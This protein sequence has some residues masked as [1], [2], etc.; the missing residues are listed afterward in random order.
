MSCNT[1]QSMSVVLPH[2]VSPT[3]DVSL[4]A[5]IEKIN[6]GWEQSINDVRNQ[7]ERV[8]GLKANKVREVAWIVDQC[9]MRT[10]GS[11]LPKNFGHHLWMVPREGER[12]SGDGHASRFLGPKRGTDG[13][14]EREKGREG[15]RAIPLRVKPTEAR[16]E[17]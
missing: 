14:R 15:A 2:C 4:S 12:E 1:Y 5:R 8:A 17:I 11:K 16:G 9:K 7:G 3:R 6:R 13:L 10:R